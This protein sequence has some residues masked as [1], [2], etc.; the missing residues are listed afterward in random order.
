M[1]TKFADGRHRRVEENRQQG[2]EHEKDAQR[3]AGGR[4]VQECIAVDAP[5]L[6][7]FCLRLR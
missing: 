4:A 7:R 1:K 6:G 2:G 5:R 3:S